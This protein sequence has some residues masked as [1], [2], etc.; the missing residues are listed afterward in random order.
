MSELVTAF[1]LGNAAIINNVC[2]LPLYPGLMAFLAGNAGAE[3]AGNKRVRMGILGAIVLS[4]VLTMMTAVALLLYGFNA[5]TDDILPVLLPAIYG[6]VFILGAMMLLGYNPWARFQTVQVPVL[7]NPIGGA[8]VY[9]LLLGPMTLPCI[10]PLIVTAFALG[11]NNA[12]ALV[13]GILYFLAFGIGFG[14]PLVAL[15]LV[16]VQSQRRFIKWMTRHHDAFTRA[17]GVLLIGIAIFGFVVEVLPEW[18]TEDVA[19]ADVRWEAAA[20]LQNHTE[21][22]TALVFTPDNQSLISAGGVGNA[23]GV[24]GGQGKDFAFRTWDVSAGA[25]RFTWTAAPTNRTEVLR[26]SPDGQWLVSGGWDSQVRVWD[27]TAG[28]VV[29]QFGGH[30]ERIL[31]VAFSPD[32]TRLVTGDVAGTVQ[33]WRFDSSNWPDTPETMFTA[34]TGLL[35]VGLSGVDTLATAHTDGTIHLW[36]LNTPT[37][38]GILEGHAGH[39][40][41]LLWDTH[42]QTLLSAG[43]DG[44]VRLW[45]TT[46]GELQRTLTAPGAA[47]PVLALALSP[48]GRWLAQSDGDQVVVWETSDYSRPT[49]TFRQHQTAVSAL[50]FSADGKWLASAASDGI[51]HTYR[52]P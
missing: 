42:T 18:R 16:A 20:T 36:N 35:D 29:H 15:P 46:T 10:A 19:V 47:D 52:V 3:S 34:P 37:E 11:A 39:V 43:A 26:Y 51:I 25:L 49:I 23:G 22:V 14:W 13:D 41:A 8:Y 6:L 2:L 40:E 31:G 32:G 27:V 5:V 7:K 38:T 30:Q 21:A 33:V 17:A 28:V 24:F 48:N 44:T 9:G 45:N 1:G 50:A 12:T 4:G